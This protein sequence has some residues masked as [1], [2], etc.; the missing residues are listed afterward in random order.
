[1]KVCRLA[2]F[3]PVV[4]L[5]A[6]ISFGPKAPPFLLSLTPGQAVQA[7]AARTGEQANALIV[8]VPNT[9]QKLN[10]TRIPV[11]SASGTIT[12][13][14]DA[15]WTDKPAQLF[16]SLLAETIAARG[17]LV[18]NEAD[19]GGKATDYL[20]GELVDFGVFEAE[21]QAVVTFDAVR[22]LP[23]GRVETRRFTAAMPV[24]VID[25]ASAGSAL[26]AAANEVA[27]NVASWIAG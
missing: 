23:G 4:L 27:Q 9:P 5:S 10:V 21:A 26:N 20:A 8:S 1:M 25:P 13:L 3:A 11:T 22:Q 18:L 16:R 17:R 6:C 19:A 14:T 15:N 2:I 12:Y 24:P 7:G